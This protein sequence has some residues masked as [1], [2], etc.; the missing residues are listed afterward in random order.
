MSVQFSGFSKFLRNE[1]APKPGRLANVI[2]ISVLTVLVVVVSETFKIPFP[3][4]SAYIVF[5]VSKEESASTILTGVF[6]ALAV[7]VAVF[8]A[9]AVYMISAGEPGLRIPLIALVAFLGL[10]FSRVSSFGPAAFATGF[11]M[12]LSLTLIDTIP[13]FAP[14]PSTEILTQT[15]LWL[16][17]VV[18]VPV[19]FVVIANVLAGNRPPDLFRRALVDRLTT[20][21][22]SLLFEGGLDSDLRMRIADFNRVGTVE[23]LRYYKLSGFS[24]KR[25]S[26]QTAADQALIARTYEV[27]TL[28]SEWMSLTVADQ[29][30]HE[31]AASCGH[32][33]LSVAQ[34]LD[35][36]DALAL[37]QP[38]PVLNAKLWETDPS[39]VLLL[40]R[41]IELVSL[42][43]DLLLERTANVPDEQKPSPA[44]QGERTSLIP[45]AFSNPD[46]VRFALKTTLAVLIAYISYNLLDWPEIRT[47]MITCFFVTV[48]NVGETV[49]KMTLRITGALIGGSIGLATVI[50]VMP[51]LTSIWDLCLI[52][53]AMAFI[54]GWVATSS[55][56][57]S[58]AGLQIALAFF[59]CVLVGYG[60][61]V[62]LAMARDRVVGIL[63]GN[64]IVW[65]VFSNIWPVSAAAH[66]QEALGAAI[67]NLS[68]FFGAKGGDAGGK[69]IRTDTSVFAFDNALAR[70]W[71]LLSFDPFEPHAVKREHKAMF[72]AGDVDAVQSLY[73]PEIILG[74]EDALGLSSDD[75]ACRMSIETAQ[76][77]NALSSW[78]E[79]LSSFV[80]CGQADHL[81]EPPPDAPALITTCEPAEAGARC[82]RLLAHARWY[83]E[84]SRRVAHLYALAQKD[85]FDTLTGHPESGE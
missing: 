10:F 30:A 63:F 85:R 83:R 65:V 26:R 70:T 31:A 25:S 42:F 47:V 16:W 18:M 61:T 11:V 24:Q 41:L 67:R 9:I 13:S 45:D 66:A 29:A 4:Y 37:E 54:A 15:V 58:Y 8:S 52:I 19:G 51:Y 14:L 32:V 43:P 39:A 2:R 3:A 49:H 7:T 73:G 71:R 36:G 78:L 81:S 55:E 72:D 84:L 20:A 57:L 56:W 35:T 22:R 38:L 64:I 28:L 33:L 34:C 12:T 27:L 75:D 77:R 50:F 68:G 1:L 53:G 17:V 59:L 5:F 80:S 44:K 60:P 48:G 21:G 76:Y 74:G 69:H 23:L 62:D 79:K 82:G 40:E 6:A 46:H